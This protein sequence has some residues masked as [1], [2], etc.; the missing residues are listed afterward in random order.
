MALLDCQVDRSQTGEPI[1]YDKTRGASIQNRAHCKRACAV[2]NSYIGPTN[3]L[4]SSS[5]KSGPQRRKTTGD[6]CCLRLGIMKCCE[7]ALQIEQYREIVE[8]AV[9]DLLVRPSFFAV[10]VVMWRIQEKIKT[11]EKTSR[12]HEG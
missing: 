2:F 5:K 4:W 1:R 8:T 11:E 10:L 6:S 7:F 3:D 12:Q 9:F